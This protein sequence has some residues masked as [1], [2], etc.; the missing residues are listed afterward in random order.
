MLQKRVA[1]AIA[2]AVS[3]AFSQGLAFKKGQSAI[4]FG[5]NATYLYGV[6]AI[7]A[8]DVGAINNMFSFGADVMYYQRTYRI[9]WWDYNY[10]YRYLNPNFRFAFH[11]FGIPAVEGGEHKWLSKFDPYAVFKVGPRFRWYK[12]EW[13]WGDRYRNKDMKID[14]DWGL[15]A[16]CRFYVKEK[17]HFFVEGGTGSWVLGLGTN[18]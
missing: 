1:L 16:G 17:F 7:V 9:R 5:F 10:S 3:L 18:F 4:D 12:E 13:D 2:L 15:S 8:W 6:G 11:P 14:V